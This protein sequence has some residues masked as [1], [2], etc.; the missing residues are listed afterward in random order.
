MVICVLFLFSRWMHFTFIALLQP[1]MLK[2]GKE[3]ESEGVFKAV[4]QDGSKWDG[5]ERRE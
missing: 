1:L 4:G 2:D 5:R 3:S